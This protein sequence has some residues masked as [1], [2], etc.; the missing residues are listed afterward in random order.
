MMVGMTTAL[1]VRPRPPVRTARP[2]R[3]RLSLF[4][5]VTILAASNVVSNRIWPE[6]YV[7]WNLAMTALLVAGARASGLTWHDL[8]LHGL[9]LRRGALVGAAVAGA[10]AV[11]YAIALAHPATRAAFLDA[12]AAGPLGAVLFAALVRIPL[13]T[14]VLEETAF[15]GVLPAL[16][17]GG[18][19]RAT[20]VSSALFGV[21]HVLPAIGMGSANA[22]FG[23][24]LGGWGT[25]GEIAV[26]VLFTFA[27]GVWLSALRRWGGHLVAPVLAHVA[28]N[29][30]GVLLA[31]WMITHG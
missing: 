26:A 27:A 6:G 17:G 14:A 18:W 3:L 1:E 8:G 7:V 16:I 25:V 4:A 15:R 24:A 21:W 30:L 13:G 20:L 22:A 9:R 31:W 28:T 2:L 10:V 19:W 23:A 11:F 5:A 29:S 12:R